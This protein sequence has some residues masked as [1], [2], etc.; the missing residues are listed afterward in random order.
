MQQKP[1]I[2]VALLVND[3]QVEKFPMIICIAFD[4]LH[5]PIAKNGEE[6]EQETR[7]KCISIH[8]IRSMQR[9]KALT[10]NKVNN[11]R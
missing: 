5:Y 7:V 9:N 2:S 6:D 3:L 10:E 1:L 4:S 8:R 11:I